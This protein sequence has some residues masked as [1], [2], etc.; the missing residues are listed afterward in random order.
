ME[1]KLKCK[2]PKKQTFSNF[3]SNSLFFI[4]NTN[5]INDNLSIFLYF[6]DKVCKKE[7]LNSK[8]EGHRTGQVAMFIFIRMYLILK[9]SL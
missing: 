1:N 9:Q 4:I 6:F 5:K 7:L 3:L 2:K 8:L